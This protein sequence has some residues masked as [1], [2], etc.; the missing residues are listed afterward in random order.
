MFLGFLV[1]SMIGMLVCSGWVMGLSVLFRFVVFFF[2]SGS[3]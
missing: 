2:V 1:F 3:W